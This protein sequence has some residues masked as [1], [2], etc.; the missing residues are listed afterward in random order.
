MAIL[1]FPANPTNGQEYTAPTGVIYSYDG[2]YN[3]WTAFNTPAPSGYIANFTHFFNNT[4]DI[5]TSLTS[6]NPQVT[7][8]ALNPTAP[9]APASVSCPYNTIYKKY[10][11]SFATAFGDTTYTID[12]YNVSNLSAGGS[13][14][15]YNNYQ[16]TNKTVSGFVVQFCIR[17]IDNPGLFTLGYRRNFSIAASA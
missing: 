12:V 13:S 1:N 16:I 5:T 17:T 7:I 9:D 14:S 3:V 11:I 15:A 10:G 2:Q 4:T 6:S 8:T